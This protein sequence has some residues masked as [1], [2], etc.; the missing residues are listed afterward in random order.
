MRKPR[1]RLCSG[2]LPLAWP[3]GSASALGLYR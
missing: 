2:R 1:A 3:S